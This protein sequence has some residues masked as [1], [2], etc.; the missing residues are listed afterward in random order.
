MRTVGYPVAAHAHASPTGNA[1]HNGRLAAVLWA[2]SL[3]I[4]CKAPA[5]CSPVRGHQ[6]TRLLTS[7]TTTLR[8]MVQTCHMPEVVFRYIGSHIHAVHATSYNDRLLTVGHST[9]VCSAKWPGT[10]R[11]IVATGIS[12]CQVRELRSVRYAECCPRGPALTEVN[13]Y[14]VGYLQAL[15]YR[16]DTRRAI[17]ACRMQRLTRSACVFRKLDDFEATVWQP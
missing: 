8:N 17:P 14:P 12:N 2:Q 3:T 15:G 7:A 16:K 5:V 9:S 6:I 10:L 1:C 13:V 11:P 4:I